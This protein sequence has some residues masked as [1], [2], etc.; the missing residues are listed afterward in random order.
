MGHAS[1]ELP[2]L[3]VATRNRGKL[4]ELECMLHEAPYRLIS[5]DEIGLDFEVEETGST[6]AENATLKATTYGEA[7]G[8]PTLADDSGLEVDALG[9]AP[10]V[11][12]SRYAGEGANDGD[13]VALLLHNLAD[14]P[15]ENRTARF[16]CAIAIALPN[17]EVHVVEGAAEGVIT[18]DPR[19]ENGFGYDPVFFLPE[20][21]RTLAELPNEHKNRLSHRAEAVQKAL[22]VL[23]RI[24]DGSRET[25]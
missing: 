10:G 16:R 15:Q 12:S 4:A 5:L 13:R 21:G 6:F 17:N 9:G 14:H 22:L 19:G 7:A 3:L 11:L 1:P 23:Q 24:A 25:T 2:P 8:L 18:N 20:I